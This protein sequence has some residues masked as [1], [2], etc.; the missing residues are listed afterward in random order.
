M[1]Y[2]VDEAMEAL[3][4]QFP[5]EDHFFPVSISEPLAGFGM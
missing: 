4:A 5:E 3:I 2:Y 1:E